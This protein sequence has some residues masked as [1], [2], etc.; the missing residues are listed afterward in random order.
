MLPSSVFFLFFFL[1]FSPL[2]TAQQDHEMAIAD[3]LY[4]FELSRINHDYDRLLDHVYPELFTLIPREMLREKMSQ[5]PAAPERVTRLEDFKI[6]HLSE[7]LESAAKLFVRLR[8][9]YHYSQSS[10]G[11][12]VISP[13]SQ[14]QYV[15][16]EV[17]AVRTDRDL[18]WY[19]LEVE[20]GQSAMLSAII[21]AAALQ[22]R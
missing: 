7:P 17:L 14:P 6:V 2:L 8:F 19:F 20:N 11:G 16:R 12:K 1:F 18:E 21:P 9:S 4:S 15:S 3:R 5:H 13:T 22:L 10:Q